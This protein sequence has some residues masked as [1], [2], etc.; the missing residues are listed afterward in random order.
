MKTILAE[1]HDVI[2]S[3]ENKGFE[4]E[5]A[6]LHSIFI[7][8]AAV[9]GNLVVDGNNYFIYT[10]NP[11]D[12]FW[13]LATSWKDEALKNSKGVVFELQEFHDVINKMNPGIDVG[14]W[15]GGDRIKVP[16]KVKREPFNWNSLNPLPGIQKGF[17][18]VGKFLK[19][20]FFPPEKLPAPGTYDTLPLSSGEGLITFSRRLGLD[21]NTIQA[22]NPDFPDGASQGQPV[23]VPK[24]TKDPLMTS[25]KKAPTTKKTLK[26]FRVK[27]KPIR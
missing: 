2:T 26:D 13:N 15:H 17:E 24:G 10:V 22:M 21:P 27:R 1:L 6:E 5:A 23:R 18:G 20:T 11:G 14:S 7:R 4:K 8:Q 19:D 3:L 16:T 9:G 25:L 12:I